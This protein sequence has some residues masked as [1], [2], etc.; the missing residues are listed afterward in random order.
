MSPAGARRQPRECRDR[1]ALTRHLGLRMPTPTTAQ[2]YDSI[3]EFGLLYDS[4][5]AYAARGDV[6]FYV[7]E[8]ARS[9]GPLLEIGCGT[10]RV[11]LPVARA[12]A[13]VVGLDGSQQ[14]LARCRAKMADESE[15]TRERVTL[16]E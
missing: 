8:A 4:V 10:G 12:G 15:A 11:L 7:A 14:M 1:V 3:P 2:S 5:P 13:T 9:R 6:R 16:R